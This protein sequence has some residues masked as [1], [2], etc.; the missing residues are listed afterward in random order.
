MQRA[1]RAI[2]EGRE[3]GV[4][5]LPSSF[6]DTMLN[7]FI[8]RTIEDSERVNAPIDPNDLLDLVNADIASRGIEDARS[9]K[10]LTVKALDALVQKL[11]GHSE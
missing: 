9:R 8:V 3:V 1:I 2:R 10:P 11:G 6:S 4:A 5:G 7:E